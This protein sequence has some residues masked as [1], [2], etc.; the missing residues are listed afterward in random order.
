MGRGSSFAG[1]LSAVARDIARSKREAE[2]E[3]RRQLRASIQAQR[4]ETRQRALAD[5][6]TKLRYIEER[7][8]EAEDKTIEVQERVDELRQI[9]QHTLSVDD[10]IRFSSLKANEEFPA[11]SPK[12]WLTI[13]CSPPSKEEYLSDKKPPSG[14]KKLIPGSQDRYRSKRMQ[15]EEK[16]Q[17]AFKTY[18]EKEA[19]RLTALEEAKQTYEESKKMHEAK[20]REKN[21]EI[22]EFEM[23]YKK[24]HPKAIVGYST[25]VLERSNYPEGFPQEFRVAYV[26]ESKQLVIDYELPS[27]EIV[28][29]AAEFKYVKAKNVIEEK[30]RKGADI[31]ELYQDVIASTALRTCHE[32]FEADQGNHIENLVFSG[33]VQ[34]IDVSTGKD[35][36]PCLISLRVTKERFKELDLSRIDKKACLRNLGAQVSPRPYEVQPVKPIIEFDMVDK[37]F[38]EQ[39]DI[40][41][42]LESRPNLMDLNPF[43]FENLVGNL[44]KQIGLETKLTRSS[45]DGGVDVVAYDI[46]PVIGGKVVIQ[47]KRYKNTV[48][49]SAVRDLYGTMMNEGANKGILVTTSGYGPD[50]FEFAKDKPIELIDGG[51]LLYLLEQSGVKARIVFPEDGK[52]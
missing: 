23:N 45:K 5:K 33:F 21:R 14:L 6:E 22:D 25:I 29:K 17:V 42:E 37:R 12:P 43:E 1:F 4:Y 49:V 10:S 28:P 15:E 20:V 16:Y 38:V 3:H 41:S 51:Q 18:Q 35:I 39:S 9:L 26:P 34:T 48:G 11:F 40:L 46:R 19:E 52:A 27:S 44:F 50:A 7:I 13:P 8:G 24:C 30:P 31:R 2:A 47:A 36:R 32:I